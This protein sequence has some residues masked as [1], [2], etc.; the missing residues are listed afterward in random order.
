MRL[1]QKTLCVFEF[2]S[3]G[4]DWPRQR[5]FVQPQAGRTP[6][7][8]CVKRPLAARADEVLLKQARAPSDSRGGSGA[9]LAAE[10]SRSPGKQAAS[11]LHNP[12]F[13]HKPLF[14]KGGPALRLVFL[15]I[16]FQ[17]HKTAP[18]WT[19][20]SSGDAGST[21]ARPPGDEACLHL[22]PSKAIPI[23]STIA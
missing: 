7:R 1:S 5:A 2:R 23:A 17:E 19:P 14:K 20:C 8:G 13:S 22:R 15:P 16:S 4:A 6:S 11:P 21:A 12:C 10:R 3:T 18:G 9:A